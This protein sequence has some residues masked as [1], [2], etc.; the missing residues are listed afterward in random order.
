MRTLLTRS[1]F[2]V[3]FRGLYF[4]GRD[5]QKFKHSAAYRLMEESGRI[6]HIS[7][8][9]NGPF[10]STSLDDHP[11]IVITS[12]SKKVLDHKVYGRH[13]WGRTLYLPLPTLTEMESIW[14]G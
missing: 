4:L 10:P 14:E 3:H 1:N 9:E 5:H 8:S 7:D 13:N 2:E 6:W 11:Q 12:P